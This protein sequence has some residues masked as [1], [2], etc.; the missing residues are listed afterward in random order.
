MLISMLLIPLAGLA[1][2]WEQIDKDKALLAIV[3]IQVGLFSAVRDFDPVTFRNAI[4]GHAELA[5]LFDLPVVMTTSVQHGPNGPLPND[6]VAMFPDAVVIERPGEINAWDNAEFR[7][8]VEATG[9]KQIIIAGI[10]TDVCTAFLALSLREA[11]YSVWANAE[12]SG[13]VSPLV[14]DISNDRM[15][16]AGVH[17]V[18]F[19][20]ILSDLLRDWRT[21][22]GPK[23][24]PFLDKYM[25]AGGFVARAH[26]GA[27]KNGTIV[28]GE[29]GL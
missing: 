12:A 4:Y 26:L 17:V 10:M 21:E 1:T 14:R 23:I 5:K 3:D 7:A 8:A 11:G 2:A 24:L 22:A 19:F 9:R 13:T 16:R 18:S 6:M 15:A 20:A 25:P 29:E 27:I 28:P